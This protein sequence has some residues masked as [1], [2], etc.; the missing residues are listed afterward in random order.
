MNCNAPHP[1]IHDDQPIFTIPKSYHAVHCMI[2]QV[3]VMNFKSFGAHVSGSRS[4][5]RGQ[6]ILSKY[7]DSFTQFVV[8]DTVTSTSSQSSKSPQFL[9]LN[10]FV[11]LLTFFVF[12]RLL[13]FSVLYIDIKASSL[14]FNISIYFQ[15]NGFFT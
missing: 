1:A 3:Q 10:V 9:S 13:Y 7:S 4:I 8:I 12:V 2:F 6:V 14:S 11:G 5:V 15:T